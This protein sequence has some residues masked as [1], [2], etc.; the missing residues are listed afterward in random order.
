MLFCLPVSDENILWKRTVLKRN[1]Q[2]FFPSEKI[3]QGKKR[4]IFKNNKSMSLIVPLTSDEWPKLN[5]VVTKKSEHKAQSINQ[6]IKFCLHPNCGTT[7]GAV[8]L[9][10]VCVYKFV[11]PRLCQWLVLKQTY[12]DLKGIFWTL[13][14]PVGPS[15]ALW[16]WHACSLVH[17]L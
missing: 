6:S 13:I 12:A 8:N 17:Y 15:E 9:S 4:Y 3:F 1:H 5:A 11:N 7:K 14:S 10:F 16:F 2:K